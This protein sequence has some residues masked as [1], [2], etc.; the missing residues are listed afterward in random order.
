MGGMSFEA[1]WEEWERVTVRK[2]YGMKL[3]LL[4]GVLAVAVAGCASVDQTNDEAIKQYKKCK[5]AGMDAGMGADGSFY[6][7]PPKEKP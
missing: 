2:G 6:C 4:L 7:I 1:R 5:D 3:A